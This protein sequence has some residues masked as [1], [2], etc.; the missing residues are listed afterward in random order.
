[1]LHSRDVHGR[2]EGLEHGLSFEDGNGHGLLRGTNH[3]RTE[4]S[5]GCWREQIGNPTCD[6]IYRACS[7]LDSEQASFHMD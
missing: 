2:M 5:P 1:L 7:T 6:A 4:S 3:M